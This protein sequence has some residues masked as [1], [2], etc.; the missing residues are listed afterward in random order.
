M[1]DPALHLET[2]TTE[3]ADSEC[4][5]PPVVHQWKHGDLSP[6]FGSL[7]MCKER[8]GNGVVA[9]GEDVGFNTDLIADGAFRGK[10]SAIHLGCDFFNDY[11]SASAR[12]FHC[13]LMSRS[14]L[15]SHHCL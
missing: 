12:F 8:S 4:G 3:I 13:H 10:P 11:P 14:W 1:V 6:L 5:F 15:L 2:I 7:A 9:V